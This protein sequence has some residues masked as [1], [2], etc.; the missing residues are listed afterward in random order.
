M[1]EERK[2]GRK[3]RGREKKGREGKDGRKD[4]REGRNEVLKEVKGGK[5]REEV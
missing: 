5:G 1:E 2:E 3:G 4:G